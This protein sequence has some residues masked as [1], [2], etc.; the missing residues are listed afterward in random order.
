M[1]KRKEIWEPKDKTRGDFWLWACIDADTKLV[2]SHRIGKRDMW[3]GRMFV[4]D[5]RAR[6]KGSL[7]LQSAPRGAVR[8]RTGA[9][10]RAIG[11]PARVTRTTTVPPRISVLNVSV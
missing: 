7:N 11:W 5:V 1:P 10:P 8:R 2:F 3:T 9:L 6:V 4:E